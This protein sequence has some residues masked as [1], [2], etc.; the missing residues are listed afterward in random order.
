MNRMNDCIFCK[1]VAGEIP[2]EKLYEDE[3]TLAFLDIHPLRSG[4]TLVIPKVHEPDI[5]HLDDDIFV[6]VMLTA[7]KMARII[8]KELKPK[9]VGL[10]VAGWDV[11]H[12]HVHVVPMEDFHDLTSKILL[13]NR[14]GNPTQ[15]ERA[16]MRARLAVR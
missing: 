13:E 11:P 5:H 16:A 10:L 4:H 2:A 1:I 9:R 7:K 15:K 3:R 12:A 14:R 6:A 8:E